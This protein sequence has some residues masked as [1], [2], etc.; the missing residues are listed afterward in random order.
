MGIIRHSNSPRASLL[1]IIPKPG[2]GWGPCSDFRCLNNATVDN[3]YLLPHIQDFNSSLVDKRIFSK[4]DLARVYHKIP[5]T[6]AN[7][8]RT[9]VITPFRLWESLHMP[10]SLKNAAEAFQRLM[11]DILI[12]LNFIL[13]CLDDILIASCTNLEH[14]A[15]LCDVFLLLSDNSMVINHKKSDFDVSE[16]IYLGHH[17]ITSGIMPLESRVTAASDFSVP[18]N[19]VGLQC[20]LSMST[21]TATSC[22]CWLKSSIPSRCHQGQRAGD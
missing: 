2:G 17:V 1:H 20:F 12:D 18:I 14:E 19:K 10:F 11:D 3:R 4:V 21:T 16:L 13:V 5:V 15:H 8:P 7:I 6:L 9:A 22:R